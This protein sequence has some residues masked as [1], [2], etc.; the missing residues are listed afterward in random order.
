VRLIKTDANMV[1]VL[2]T[3]ISP[4]GT[5]QYAS[6]TS[7]VTNLQSPW[8]WAFEWDTG[9][10]PVLGVDSILR[11]QEYSLASGFGDTKNYV[12]DLVAP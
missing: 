6:T 1:S 9:V 4:D 11:F 7:G 2:G 12:V 8:E 10:V 5:Q 3:F